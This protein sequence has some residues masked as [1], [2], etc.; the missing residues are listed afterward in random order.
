M[1]YAAPTKYPITR[2]N[3]ITDAPTNFARCLIDE[4]GRLALLD[5]SFERS[6]VI[7]PPMQGTLFTAWSSLSI[8][9]NSR[10]ENADRQIILDSSG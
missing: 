4:D 7:S 8:Q 1:T 10:G 6:L 5:A 9:R 3:A 2:C